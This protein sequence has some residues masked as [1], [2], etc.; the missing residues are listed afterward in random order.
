MT[1]DDPEAQAVLLDLL[2]GTKAEVQVAAAR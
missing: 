1:S 2:N